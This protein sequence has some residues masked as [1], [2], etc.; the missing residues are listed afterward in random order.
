M[1]KPVVVVDLDGVLA[2]FCF[3]FTEM[4][5]RRPRSNGTQE[6]WTFDATPLQ[7]KRAWARIDQSKT[8]WYSLVPL[9]S[10][11]E[12]SDARHLAR[13]ADFVYMT[14]REERGNDTLG[15]S[16]RWLKFLGMPEGAIVLE[17]DKLAGVRRLTGDVYGIIDDRPR[18]I[19]RLQHAGEPV[20]VRD[21]QYNRRSLSGLNAAKCAE[22]S[23]QDG[24]TCEQA[25]RVSSFGEF[26]GFMEDLCG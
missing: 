13:S 9:V 7:I 20:Y 14:G 21:W 3:G 22:Q 26:C 23:E 8:F 25:M 16:T 18:N 1:T 17:G 10:E 11:S 12:V 6:T 15:Q 2:D 24:F 4:L 19:T 5:Y